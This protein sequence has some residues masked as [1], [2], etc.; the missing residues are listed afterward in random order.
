VVE[1]VAGAAERAGVQPGDVVIAVNGDPVNSIDQVRNAISKS[2][3]SAALLIQ[4]GEDR[5]FVP[6]RIG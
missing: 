3:K 1:Q 2:S 4:R 5:I 6:V